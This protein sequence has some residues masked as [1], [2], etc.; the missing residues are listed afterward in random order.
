VRPALSPQCPNLLREFGSFLSRGSVYHLHRC[1]YGHLIRFA[2]H[3]HHSG[4]PLRNRLSPACGFRLY[5]LVRLP[6]PAFANDGTA[7]P[8]SPREVCRASVLFL[9]LRCGAGR[10][11]CCSRKTNT[12]SVPLVYTPARGHGSGG[13]GLLRVPLPSAICYR[14]PVAL[15][16]VVFVIVVL[17][18]VVIAVV[19]LCDTD[20]V[21]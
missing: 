21:V 12:I 18:F 1:V 19:V 17:V 10:C 13:R 7:G 3:G 16:Q 15:V 11:S 6:T 4:K 5:C 2:L 20:N 8:A 9:P 14:T